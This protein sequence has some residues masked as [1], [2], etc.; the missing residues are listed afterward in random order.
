M[1]LFVLILLVFLV[2]LGGFL[3]LGESRYFSP[4]ETLKFFN[5][6]RAWAVPV[7]FG[8]MMA[9][10]VLPVPSSAIMNW[11]GSAYGTVWGGLVGAAACVAASVA[12]YWLCRWAGRPAALRIAGPKDL[13]RTRAFFSRWGTLAVVA[14]RPVPMLAEAV[15]CLAGMSRMPF[16]R[17]LLASTVGAVPFALVFAY[18]GAMG[19][20]LEEPL[21]MMVL[22]I[23]IPMVLWVPVAIVLY[24]RSRSAPRDGGA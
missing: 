5:R 22:S 15:F 13:D 2:I 4:D 14:A 8:L 6:Y 11:Y 23:V 21:T 17:F 20:E 1:R 9:D 18:L 10:L 19:R 24:R 12:A 7:G 3:L 16:G